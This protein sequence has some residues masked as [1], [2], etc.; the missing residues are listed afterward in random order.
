[1]GELLVVGTF[2]ATM[3]VLTVVLVATREPR[4]LEEFASFQLLERMLTASPTTAE[5]IRL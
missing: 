4:S 3:A 1:M 5:A 2:P